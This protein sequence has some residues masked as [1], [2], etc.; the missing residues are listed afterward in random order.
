VEVFPLAGDRA[1]LGFLAVAE[2]QDGIVMEDMWDCV[3]VV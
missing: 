3:L 1:D 2:H